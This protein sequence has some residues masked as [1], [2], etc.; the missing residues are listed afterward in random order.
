MTTKFFRKA[1]KVH[2]VALVTV[3]RQSKYISLLIPRDT[4]NEVCSIYAQMRFVL[5]GVLTSQ[6][7][8]WVT[9]VLSAHAGIAELRFAVVHSLALTLSPL[10]A[11]IVTCLTGIDHCISV[12]V[13]Q[14]RIQGRAHY[15][16]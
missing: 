10:Q 9:D 11:T 8:V 14:D 15:L 1:S 2:N 5:A 7:S 3:D 13:V 16:R 6:V 12:G 4:L